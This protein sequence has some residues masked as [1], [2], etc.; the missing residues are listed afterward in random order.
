MNEGRVTRCLEGNDVAGVGNKRLIYLTNISEYLLCIRLCD[1]QY[2]DPRHKGRT[3][4]NRQDLDLRPLGSRY[5]F[6]AV[7][8][9]FERS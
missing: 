3:S 7:N 9:P 6:I 1:R 8:L 5:T 4:L 2:E